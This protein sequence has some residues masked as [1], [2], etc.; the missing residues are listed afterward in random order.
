M[1]VCACMSACVRVCVRVCVHACMPVCVCVCVCVCVVCSVRAKGVKDECCV[2]TQQH[3]QLQLALSP[4]PP[5]Y[6]AIMQE[7]SIGRPICIRV[8][9]IIIE[10]GAS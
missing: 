2:Q 3:E 6:A 7:P 1:H 4:L 9:R 5:Q 10:V 8:V